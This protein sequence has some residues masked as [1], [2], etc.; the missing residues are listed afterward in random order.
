MWLLLIQVAQAGPL[1]QP[2]PD[3]KVERITLSGRA[4]TETVGVRVVGCQGEAG[5]EAVLEARTWAAELSV[6][7]FRGVGVYGVL[8]HRYEAVQAA[9]YAGTGRSWAL[10]AR[11]AA[12]LVG[13]LGVAADARYE[14]SE[15]EGDAQDGALAGAGD[16]RWSSPRLSLVATLGQPEGGG[17]GWL[18]VQAAPGWKA[19]LTPLGAVDDVPLVEVTLK[20]TLPASAVFGLAGVSEELGLP[21]RRSARVSAG[22]EAWMGQTSGLSAWIGIG[23]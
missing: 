7:L 2:S 9:Q 20:P 8:S 21:W 6:A 23:Y 16:Q 13:P 11:L 5:C 17:L 18:G 22:A 10:G 3:P 19:E 14:R 1:G 4:E 15:T 12:P